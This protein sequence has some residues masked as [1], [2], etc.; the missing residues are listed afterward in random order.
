MDEESTNFYGG[1]FPVFTKHGKVHNNQNM[2]LVL[3]Q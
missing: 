2:G 1:T 3:L